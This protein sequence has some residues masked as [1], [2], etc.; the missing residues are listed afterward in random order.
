MAS[1]GTAHVLVQK[2][3]TPTVE[4]M[5]KLITTNVFLNACTRMYYFL[6]S[7]K[8]NWFIG[9]SGC[10]KVTQTKRVGLQINGDSLLNLFYM[11]GTINF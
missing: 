1:E 7:Y 8:R 5:G 10:C 2:S 3:W 11:F 4:K 9:V 6:A